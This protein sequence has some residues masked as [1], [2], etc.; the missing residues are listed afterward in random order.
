MYANG[1]QP[2]YIETPVSNQVQEP[3]YVDIAP[4]QEETAPEYIQTVA[5]QAYQELDNVESLLDKAKIAKATMI[6]P[7]TDM[8]DVNLSYNTETVELLLSHQVL[9]SQ[10]VSEIQIS[11]P[12]TYIQEFQTKK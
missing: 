2:Q 7:E 12:L 9:K 10:Y 3:Q 4:V 11:V 1:V 5:P 6:N 8:I